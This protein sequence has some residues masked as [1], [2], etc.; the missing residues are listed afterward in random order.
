ME[1]IDTSKLER[2]IFAAK[3]IE[4]LNALESATGLRIDL[5]LDGSARI[6]LVASSLLP[7]SCER[8]PKSP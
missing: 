7:L 5:G 4:D 3:T 6:S 1:K 2:E 8:L